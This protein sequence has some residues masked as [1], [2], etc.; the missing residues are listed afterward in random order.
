M[1]DKKVLHAQFL[2]TDGNDN[3]TWVERLPDGRLFTILS[4]SKMTNYDGKNTAIP[5]SQFLFG[6]ISD[7]DGKTWG[8]PY[9]LYEWPEKLP[10]FVHAGFKFDRAGRLH[11]FA[12]EIHDCDI[13][14]LS[15][16]IA[17]V[18]FDSYRGENPYFSDIPA[19]NRYTGSL[20][21]AIETESGRLVVPFSTFLNGRFVSNSIYSD[22]HGTTWSASANV[23]ISDDETDP[24]TG[25]VEPVVVE[26]KPG[27]LVMLIR[28]V[29]SRLW[30]A[31]SYDEGASWSKPQPTTLV[32]SNSPAV[33]LKLPSGRIFVA[34]NDVQGQ[35]MSGVRYSSARQCLH[36]AV[37]DDGLQ[38]VHGIRT[39]LKKQV[40]DQDT[41]HNAYPTVA[42][43]DDTS[44]L[45][46]TLE[47]MGKD[48]SD[49]KVV[50]GFLSLL[51]TAFL[52][53]CKVSNNWD[54]WVCDNEKTEAGIHLTPTKEEM[55]HGIV[56]F[57]YGQNGELTLR[58]SGTM[59]QNTR[60]LLSDCYIDRYTFLPSMR[61]SGY[62]DKIGRPY[63]EFAPTACGEWVLRWD[64]TSITLSV[65]GVAVQTVEKAEN[66]GFNH[67]TVLFDGAG[68]LSLDA[69]TVTVSK[70]DLKTNITY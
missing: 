61:N 70:T 3:M 42:L 1:N 28:T 26:V 51:D 48:G 54:E 9:F 4:H 41:V 17:Y 49:W 27:V 68:D 50:Q 24:E 14:S 66:D 20:N 53:E 64:D 63:T 6:R 59:P 32:S 44:I 45:F 31:I 67:F 40:G 57:P 46:R 23:A 13:K 35:P 62:A 11:V 2:A 38:H 7:D 22:D 8:A 60:L 36:A 21:N 30:Y 29:L 65:D 69:F 15:G 5:T 19:L 55:A 25:A 10:R 39:V 52:D 12:L 58:V 56:N 47:V 34:W 18:R 16:N 37:S 43:Y 33:L